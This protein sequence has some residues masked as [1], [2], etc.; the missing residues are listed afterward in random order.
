MADAPLAPHGGCN[1]VGCHECFPQGRDDFRA[2]AIIARDVEY[3]IKVLT[4]A[5]F[6]VTKDGQTYA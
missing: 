6:T 3:A 4:D 1:W 5:G 2:K